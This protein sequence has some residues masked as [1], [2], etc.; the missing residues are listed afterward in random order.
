M[1]G[2][3]YVGNLDAVINALKDYNTTTAAID[4]SGSL[5]TR[6]HDDNIQKGD[7]SVAMVR[8][9]RIPAIFV[10]VSTAD[11][12][13]SAIGA[14]GPTKSRKE[15]N[16]VYDIFCLYHKE[17]AGETHATVLDSIG[18]MCQNI[19]GVFQ[20]EF[21]LSNTALWCQPRRT[22]IAN[23]PIDSNGATWIK[24]AMIELEAKYHFR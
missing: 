13:F 24:T 11:E 16:V 2:F 4:L 18:K 3:D 20:A 12:D 8:Q 10:R 19:E 5:T 17:G 15:K 7:P 22:T 14:T 9:D 6:I 23:V 21:Q 1:A